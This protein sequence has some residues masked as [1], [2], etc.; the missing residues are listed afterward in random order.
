M[1]DNATGWVHM[2]ATYVAPAS[3]TAVKRGAPT[4][5]IPAFDFTKGILVLFMVLY[6][7]L[8]YFYGTSGDIYKYLRFLTP[9][10]IFITGFLISHVHSSKY[11]IGNPRLPKRLFLRGLKILGLFIFLN[12]MI[13]ALFPASSVRTI[14]FDHPSF[15][16][17][18]AIFLSGNIFVDGIGK[19]TAF[20]ILVPIGYLLL[21]SAVL[22]TVCRVF[23]YV[24]YV[25]CSLLL[26]SVLLLNLNGIQSFNLELLT[27]GLL[28]VVL[29]YIPAADIN[30]LAGHP[31]AVAL[32]YCAYLAAI[33]IWDVPFLLRV[34][35]VCLTVLLIYIVGAKRGEAGTLR[36]HILLLGKYSLFGYIVQIAI[37]QVLRRAF[38]H[39]DIG[40]G[41][42]VVSF[43]AGFAL[44]M[45]SVEVVDRAR[46]KSASF[47]R[48]YRVVFA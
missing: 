9:S 1:P 41:V 13:C 5:R 46:P 7:W 25:V 48:L 30:R 21:V 37:L 19:T 34:V 20:T 42:L 6:H 18:S 36:R 4:N 3:Q 15:A 33:T 35:G 26:L 10:F 28:G 24:F 17:L 43:I 39:V 32:A 40:A 31:Y 47:D 27:I 22:L 38:M 12:L 14:L 44:T 45:I 23:K 16:N 2:T 29:G 8:N 11:G